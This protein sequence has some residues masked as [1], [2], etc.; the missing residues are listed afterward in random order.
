MARTKAFDKTA[1]LQRAMK[2]F[3]RTG[4]EGTT[5]PDLLQELGIARQS[6]Y[7]TYGTKRDL[8]IMAVKHYMD[9]KTED[10]AEL[11]EQPGSAI[12]Q[13]EYI[14]DVMIQALVDPELAQQC[15]IISS[16]VE[17]APQDAELRD[18]LQSNTEQIEQGLYRLLQRAADEGELSA[19]F[20]LQELAH[21]LAHERM[22]LIFSA[23]AGANEQQ[24][25]SIT[26]IAL[27]VLRSHRA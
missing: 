17:Q 7:D 26:K 15:F 23:K 12:G 6:L 21:F 3:G 9:G 4:Y 2:T 22:G 11:L 25:R 8:F 20:D 14:F 24:L 13:L 10:M 18:Y 5:L 1:V 27:S 19:A 16:A